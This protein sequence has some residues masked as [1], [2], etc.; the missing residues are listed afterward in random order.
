MNNLR[1]YFK[2]KISLRYLL[3]GKLKLLATV[4]ACEIYENFCFEDGGIYWNLIEL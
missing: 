1:K 4:K 3:I 2:K